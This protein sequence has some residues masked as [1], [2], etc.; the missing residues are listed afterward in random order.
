MARMVTCGE[1]EQLAAVAFYRAAKLARLRSISERQ[2]Q[3]QIRRVFGCSPQEWLNELRVAAAEQLLLA[4]RS[5]KEV[6]F[7]LG[8]KQPS[9]FCRVFKS[10][11]RMT[12]SE[13]V[14]VQTQDGLNVRR[15]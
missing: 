10:F 7:D 5:V 9:H 8:F 1:W 6:S 3:R 12:P 14:W 11:K 15:R 13:F 2:L 4:G